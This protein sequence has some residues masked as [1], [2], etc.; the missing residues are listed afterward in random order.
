MADCRATAR[1]ARVHRC[2]R[3]RSRNVIARVNDRMDHVR[4][5]GICSTESGQIRG[6][7][8][9]RSMCRHQGALDIVPV[10]EGRSM[11]RSAFAATRKVCKGAQPHRAVLSPPQGLQVRGL[12]L[13]AFI[14]PAA[15]PPHPNPPRR[16]GEGAC[17]GKWIAALHDIDRKRPGCAQVEEA[18]R[19]VVTVS[20]HQECACPST[21]RAPAHSAPAGRRA[22]Y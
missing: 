17:C 12:V 21:H 2:P 16:G 4:K 22:G 1:R 19:V 13:V 10:I 6:A 20:A 3:P 15:R 14:K 7:S 18:M 11:A 8:V 9:P 5:Q